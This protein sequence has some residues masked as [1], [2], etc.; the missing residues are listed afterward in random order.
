MQLVEHRDP[1][2]PVDAACRALNVSRASLYRSWGSTVKQTLVAR[3]RTPNPRRLDDA[4]RQHLR[5]TLHLPEFADQPPAEVWATLLS[6]GEYAEHD[7]GGASTP[8]TSPTFGEHHPQ[9]RYA[10]RRVYLTQAARRQSMAAMASEPHH[11]N[12]PARNH[13]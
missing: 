9:L 2:V 12:Q 7:V 3:V 6:R 11:L 10:G 4:A 5:D 8:S 13:R 1:E